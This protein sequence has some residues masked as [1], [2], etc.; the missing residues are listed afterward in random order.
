[1][2]TFNDINHSINKGILV[3]SMALMAGGVGCKQT[4]L[5]PA[6]ANP[7]NYLVVE[8]FIE[9]NGTDSTIF[10]LSRTVRLDSNA[11]TPEHGASVTVEGTDN[12]IFPLAETNN[13]AYGAPLPLLNSK[14]TYRL[15]ITTSGGKQYASDYVPIVTNPPFDSI[16]WVRKDNPPNAGIQVYANTHDPNNNTHYYRWEYQETWEFH[17][18]FYTTYK[19]IP[20]IG[21]QDYGPNTM[22][23]CWHSDNSSNVLVA[24]STQLSEDVIHEA[25]LVLLPLNS[26]QLQMRYSIL[27]KQYALTKDAFDWWQILQKN[28]EQIGSI[29]GVQ[30]SANPGNIHCLTDTTEQVLGFLGGGNTHSQ[31]IFITHD[32]VLP[33]D[34]ESGCVD[35]KVSATLGAAEAAYDMGVLVWSKDINPPMLHVAYKTCVDC[36]YTG[37]NTQPSFW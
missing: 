3:F 25:P 10:K 36:T 4:Y 20:G 33:W 1:M 30:P 2:R 16:S 13:G 19:Y 11:Y 29:F 17:V 18:A 14:V 23:Y 28:T 35:T 22:Y 37:Y 27:V 5:P 15:H 31:R 7:P 32:Q 34:Y 24:S 6:V 9:N 12:S 26:Q 8:G 21:L